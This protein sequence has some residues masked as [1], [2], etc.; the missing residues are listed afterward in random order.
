MGGKQPRMEYS[1]SYFHIEPGQIFW[2]SGIYNF[3]PDQLKKFREIISLPENA[4]EL[5]NILNEIAKNSEYNI[6]GSELRKTI[7]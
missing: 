3:S 5:E 1:G 4:E 6:G 7:D 2:G